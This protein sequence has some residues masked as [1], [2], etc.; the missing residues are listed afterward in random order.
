MVT[1]AVPCGTILR[2]LRPSVER[3]SEEQACYSFGGSADITVDAYL[4]EFGSPR[5]Q[6]LNDA[7]NDVADTLSALSV[8][9]SRTCHITS[10]ERERAIKAHRRDV[11]D[12]AVRGNSFPYLK[13]HFLA[14]PKRSDFSFTCRRIRLISLAVLI[15][16]VGIRCETI[17]QIVFLFLA[18]RI[19][20]H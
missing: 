5:L 2:D 16:F 18:A 1:T 19:V 4:C 15:M 9:D 17:R 6:I 12:I 20:S 3:V 7:R 8:G 11:L 14:P 13:S 10:C